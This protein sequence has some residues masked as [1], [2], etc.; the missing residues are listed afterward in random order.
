MQH[1]FVSSLQRSHAG[2][3]K[4]PGLFYRWG[5]ISGEVDLPSPTLSGKQ[6][7]KK[8]GFTYLQ[9]RVPSLKFS[10]PLC[11][12]MRMWGVLWRT[13]RA[14]KDNAFH[15]PRTTSSGLTEGTPGVRVWR[16]LMTSA[17]GRNLGTA[18]QNQVFGALS[19]ALALDLNFFFQ[20]LKGRK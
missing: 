19:R 12:G 18:E 2:L 3:W 13:E 10:S 15:S 9:R 5:T 1:R 17:D 6:S 7:L 14:V 20:S 11:L 16:E 8:I 4:V